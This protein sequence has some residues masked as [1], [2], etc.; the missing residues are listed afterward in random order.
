MNFPTP[1]GLLQDKGVIGE[2]LRLL[3]QSSHTV[4]EEAETQDKPWSWLAK[5]V[6]EN[7]VIHRRNGTLE[8]R[9]SECAA[10]E[11]EGFKRTDI[12]VYSVDPATRRNAKVYQGVREVRF[13]YHFVHDP[14]K[15]HHARRDGQMLA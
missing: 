13:N 14:K 12:G 8:M 6:K 3:H 1:V 4:L 2:M 15:N 10:L 9:D 11:K 7:P 5:W